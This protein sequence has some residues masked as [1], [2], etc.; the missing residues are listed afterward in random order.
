MFVFAVFLVT[1]RVFSMEKE[2]VHFFN[3]KQAVDALDAVSKD[4]DRI[5]Y[6]NCAICGK[7]ATEE[8]PL[9]QIYPTNSSC[10]AHEK[11]FQKIKFCEERI[12]DRMKTFV[13]NLNFSDR[14]LQKFL[15]TDSSSPVD[16]L[17]LIDYHKQMV[18]AVEGSLHQKSLMQYYEEVGADSLRKLFETVGN[19]ALRVQV[20]FLRWACS[21]HHHDEKA[22]ACTE[23]IDELNQIS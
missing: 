9:K 21:L 23:F 1:F 20:S 5:S 3:L 18:G 19:K 4:E 11:C 6:T 15:G 2:P 22:R 10:G 7:D 13:K 16:L 17:M 12:N 8:K 14:I